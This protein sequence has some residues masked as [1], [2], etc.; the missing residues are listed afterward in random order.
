MSVTDNQV[1]LDVLELLYKHINDDPASPGVDKAIVQSILQT[2]PK[3]ID[4]NMS[5]LV[6]KNLVALSGSATGKWTFAK[7]TPDGID[8]VENKERYANKF[9]FTQAQ[10][11]VHE[12]RQQRV[13]ETGQAQITFPEKVSIA[14]KQASDQ[15]LGARISPSEKGK[16]EKQLRSLE[17]E[18]LKTKKADLGTIQKDWKVL[19]KNAEWLTPILAQAM[20]EGIR[21]TLDLPISA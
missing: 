1:L 3:Q 9:P 10:S 20:L 7:I 16:I 11:H 21:S 6:E 18:L 14:F 13:F 4:D 19:R 15:V 5:Y 17:K 12:E 2:S 8:V